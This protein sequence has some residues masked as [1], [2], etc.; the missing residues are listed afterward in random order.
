MRA[1]L[2]FIQNKDTLAIFTLTLWHLV[3]HLPVTLGQKIFAEGD[4]QWIYLPVR[5]ELSRALHEMR[6]PL[7][8]P[9][10]QGGLPLLADGH[11]AALYPLNLILHFIFPPH[12]ALNY[13]ILFNLIWLSLGMYFF[14]RA[15]DIRPSSAFLAGLSFGASGAIIARV[16]HPDVLTTA[17]WLPW[18]LFCQVK[19]WQADAQ[20]KKKG[21]WFVLSCFSIG[22]PSLAG[23]PAVLMLCLV[24]F[25]PYGI[26]VS[27][28]GYK[29]SARKPDW[30]TRATAM[31]LFK[32]TSVTLG[33][34]I[35]GLGIGAVQIF[36]TAEL[37]SWSLRGKE[38]GK[39]FFVSYSLEPS[40]LSQ[41]ITPFA[42]LGLPS[43][44][45]MEFWGYFG[46]CPLVLAI[47]ALIFR[48]DLRTGF[49]A[50][51]AGVTLALALGGSNPMYESLYYIPLFNRFRVPARFL[52]LFLLASIMLAAIGFDE[53]QNRLVDDPPKNKAYA[54]TGLLLLLGIITLVP[55]GVDWAPEQWIEIWQWLPLILGFASISL[56]VTAIIFK[57]SRQTFQ[58]LVLGLISFDLL[59]FNLPFLSTLARTATP[60]DLVQAPRTVLAMDRNEPVARSLVMQFPAVTTSS[61]RA[62]LWSGI[63]MTFGRAGVI[64][65][66]MPFSLAL[67]RNE[68][69]IQAM[70]PAMRNLMNIR[71]YLLPLEITPPETESPLDTSQP[72]NG[73]TIDLLRDGVTIPTTTATS[74]RIVSYTDQT[75]D[76]PTGF[77]VGTIDLTL[78]NGD[79]RILPLR[80]GFET[81][82][83]AYNGIGLTKKINHTHPSETIEFP[84]YLRSI[85]RD[86]AG[87]KYV[88][89]LDI[90]SQKAPVA[91]TALR[92]NPVLAGAGLTIEHLDLMNGTN[93]VS[94]AKL[95]GRDDLQVAFRSHTAIMWDNRDAMPRAFIV[96]ASSFVPEDQMLAQLRS[97]QFD[98][99]RHVLFSED[100]TLLQDVDAVAPIND[101]VVITEYRP[102]YIR[103][104][105]KTE[106]VGYLILADAW[107]PG[108]VAKLDHG[109][110]PIL[111]ADYIFRAIL[112]QPGEHMIEFEYHPDSFAWGIWTSSLVVA[113]LIGALGVGKSHIKSH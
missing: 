4:I 41:F 27:F 29:F 91:I 53:L 105:I 13:A 80:L 103:I 101:S 90:T 32:T 59:L 2:R 39:S 49:F 12:I 104:N 102:D 74:L 78:T 16:S 52:F 63:P 7:W 22:L 56:L 61:I 60:S 107:Y 82:D 37:L 50:L 43:A 85:G 33:A 98:P 75:P 88:A 62:T 21:L 15:W 99:Y 11:V 93:S 109:Q 89:R 47:T 70:S 65:G 54:V 79:H 26:F 57:P 111:R 73:L 66:Y 108:W 28:W 34:I 67:Q 64:R 1:T 68:D 38:L 71:Y 87:K 14:V 5:T 42:A 20:G 97:S 8:T 48:C 86:F 81:A 9:L 106:R 94:L 36:P 19:F 24:A 17:S 6:L 46:I 84:A 10:V 113:L 31:H 40:T 77:P 18:M 25:V 58:L 44:E 95:L 112:V 83:W 110:V 23:S 51:M 55:T 76:L 100:H 72:E 96:H 92:V 35:L 3:L 45:N 30:R 69:Y